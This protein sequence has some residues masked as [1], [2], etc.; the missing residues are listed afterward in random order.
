MSSAAAPNFSRTS[1]A[2]VF[3]YRSNILPK[4]TLGDIITT[5]RT[6][7][8]N[9]VTEYGIA[10]LPGKTTWQRAEALINIAHPD[11]RES[12]IRAAEEQ[13]IWRRSSRR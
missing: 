4:F 2:Y 11:F 5:P 7:A 9:I 13:K 8:P 12:L 10:S 3:R 6:Q 1:A